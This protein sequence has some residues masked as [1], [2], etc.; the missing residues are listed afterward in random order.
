MFFIGSMSTEAK[1]LSAAGLH[2]CAT[3]IGGLGA[4]RFR[5]VHLLVVGLRQRVEHRSKRALSRGAE[6][7]EAVRRQE[8]LKFFHRQTIAFQLRF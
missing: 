3:D 8:R 4:A 2:R 6:P 7:A 5:R 1:G